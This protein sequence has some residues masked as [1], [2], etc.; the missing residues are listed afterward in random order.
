MIAPHPHHAVT[1]GTLCE[2]LTS[3]SY[4]VSMTNMHPPPTRF[5]GSITVKVGLG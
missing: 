4:W 3:F 5:K 2:H 1:C